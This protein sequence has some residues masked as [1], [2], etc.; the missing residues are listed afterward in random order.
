MYRIGLHCGGE[1]CNKIANANG[2][3]HEACVVQP[4]LK[5]DSPEK[6]FDAWRLPGR[7]H[8]SEQQFATHLAREYLASGDVRW[9]KE[10]NGRTDE[11]YG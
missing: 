9:C 3:D 2:W 4:D 6:E 11:D 7:N 1:F 10:G 8:S 5:W